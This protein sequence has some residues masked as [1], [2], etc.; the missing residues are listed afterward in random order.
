M[1]I[2]HHSVSAGGIDIHYV[3]AGSGPPLILL[4]GGMVSTNSIWDGAPFSYTHHVP[5]LAERFRVIAPD[6]RGCGRTNHTGDSATFARLADDVLALAAALELDR[7]ML[8]GFSEGGLTALIAGIRAPGEVGA[9]VSDAGYDM[10]DPE[11]ASWAMLRQ[12]FGGSPDA[13]R[14]DPEALVR[15]MSADPHMKAGF[16]KMVEDQNAGQGAGGWKRYASLAFDQRLRRP[17]GYG[18]DDLAAIE[19]PALILVGDR[20]PFCT[21]EDAARSYRALIAGELAILAN[22][23]HAITPA[24]INATVEFLARHAG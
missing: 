16:D 13:D 2:T 12:M 10:L 11:A 20:D 18:F 19:S 15:A 23:G 9:I 22:T 7:P 3:E 8:C 17:P 21:V 5:A 4:H 14:F 1:T 24:K 6:T